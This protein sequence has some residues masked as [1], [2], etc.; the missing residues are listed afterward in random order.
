MEDVPFNSEEEVANLRE[1]EKR[2]QEMPPEFGVIFIGVEL[3]PPT[4]DYGPDTKE[5]IITVGLRRDK[6]ILQG[7][8]IAQKACEVVRLPGK[9]RITLNVFRGVVGGYREPDSSRA[10]TNPA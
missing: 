3:H 1:I 2:V 6:E 8:L 7:E 10:D 5:L 9:V 4:G